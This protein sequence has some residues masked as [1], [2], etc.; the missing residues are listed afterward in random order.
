MA[1]AGR[2]RTGTTDDASGYGPG[3]VAAFLGIDRAL[4]DRWRKQGLVKPKAGRYDFSDIVSLREVADL[5]KAGVKPSVIRK[6]LDRMAQQRGGDEPPRALALS[7]NG[8][9][10]LVARIDGELRTVDG[11]GFFD[12]NEQQDASEPEQPIVG[13]VVPEQR[14]PA[15]IIERKTPAPELLFERALRLE[16]DGQLVEAAQ[17]YRRVIALAPDWA[18]AHYNLGNALRATGK[19]EAAEEMYR[20]TVA[21]DEDYAAAWYNLGD[22]LDEHGEVEEAI[23][24]LKSALDAEPEFTDAHY[25]L[26]S[27]LERVGR[28]DEAVPHWEAY[29]ER[30]PTSM[31]A[32][33]AR[34]ALQGR[35]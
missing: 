27:C 5:V 19:V 18:E 2:K 31:W 8:S 11:Q 23:E 3:E 16:A 17:M 35:K 33:A 29:L 6:T 7:A 25:N 9:E 22:V 1:A 21:L 12:F 10:E 24:A 26:A 4:I 15:I 13:A 14:G 30:D 20:L 34:K 28:H 32:D